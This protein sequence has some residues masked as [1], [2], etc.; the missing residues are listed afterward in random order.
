M[1][2]TSVNSKE[3]KLYEN[4]SPDMA[5]AFEII[6]QVS[7]SIPADG[8]YEVDGT[9]L[10]Y[11]VQS[12]DAKSPL[13]AKFES[14]REYIDV[15]VVLCGEEVIRFESAGKIPPCTEYRPDV[16]HYNMNKDF[17]SVRLGAGEIAIIFTDE[18][19]A[20]GIRA[21][22]ADAAVRK[23]VIKIKAN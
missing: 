5:K 2:V 19:H 23:L 9:N 10:Y 22:G 17:D 20:P 16:E 4:M 12:Y 7:A 3:N 15:Q 8:K 6:R 18:L 1:I 14:H 11:M 21:E 13:E